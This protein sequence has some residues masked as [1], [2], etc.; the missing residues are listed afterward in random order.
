MPHRVLPCSGE[1]CSMAEIWLGTRCKQDIGIGSLD[2]TLKTA[3]T[4]PHSL[5]TI[6]ISLTQN[7][8]VNILQNK[9]SFHT[10]L[11]LLQALDSIELVEYMD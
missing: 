1:E 9:I 6:Q 5:D 4:L 7:Y 8:Q 3:R 11:P 2:V 10:L